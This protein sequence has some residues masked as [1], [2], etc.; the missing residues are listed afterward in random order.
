[1][2]HRHR[3]APYT[4]QERPPDP[5]P[6]RSRA[7]LCDASG[8]PLPPPRPPPTSIPS[9]GAS[10][11]STSGAEALAVGAIIVGL[12]LAMAAGALVARLAGVC[13]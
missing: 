5:P 3:V 9:S 10:P 8:A 6:M 7:G 11:G 4:I 13:Q 12:M 1:M 2:A